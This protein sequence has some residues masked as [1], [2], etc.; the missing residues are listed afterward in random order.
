MADNLIRW[1]KLNRERPA[2]SSPG[3][4]RVLAVKAGHRKK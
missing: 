1:I 3:W 2:I 4:G